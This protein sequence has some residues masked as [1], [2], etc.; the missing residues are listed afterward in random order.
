MRHFTKNILRGFSAAVLFCLLLPWK[1]AA[2]DYP[3]PGGL[4]NDFA[5]ALDEQT[6]SALN[7]LASE[8]G[9]KTGTYVA[10]A[11]VK[12]MGGSDVD[13]Y[14]T[15]LYEAW[16]IGKKGRDKG[17]L[18]LV[19]IGDRKARIETSYGLEGI[20]P[21]GLCGQII[22]REMLPFLKKGDYSQG[23]LRGAAA[24]ASIVARDAGVELS[25]RDTRPLEKTSSPASRILS[26]LLFVFLAFIFLKNP[27]LFLL[28]LGGPGRGSGFGGGGF[29]GGSGGFGGGL[30][31]G[32][33]ASR[34][35]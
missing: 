12:D 13:S 17:A 1:A 26:A 31:G 16:G 2:G 35:W 32:G 25:F 30:S 15:G 28:F 8:L 10:V 18:I 4:V 19:S 29:G 23:I 22:D 9:G 6:K 11:M 27:F 7:G 33:G 20:L 24:I 14:A 5:G 3:R 34:S 21:D